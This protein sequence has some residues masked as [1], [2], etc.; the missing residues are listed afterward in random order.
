MSAR[1]RNPPKNKKKPFLE[2]LF[3]ILNE[4]KYS[5][6]IHWSP[7]GSC[8]VIPDPNS[9]TREVIRNN[10]KRQKQFSSFVRQL[11]LYDFEKVNKNTGKREKEMIYKHKEFNKGKK[12]DE[13][14]LIKKL[15]NK[16]PEKEKLPNLKNSSIPN[17]DPEYEKKIEE[18]EQLD[19]ASKVEEYKN[20][21][22]NEE[23]TNLTNE[24]IL[25]YLINKT[26]EK[27]DNKR[28]IRNEI[29]NLTN[30][31][32][33]L[34]ENMELLKAKIE[35]LKK[36]SMKMKDMIMFLSL[37]NFKKIRNKVNLDIDNIN[38]L[39][40]SFNSYKKKFDE[41]HH[42]DIMDTEEEIEIEEEIEEN[43]NPGTEVNPKNSEPQQSTFL[44]PNDI[45]SYP[46]NNPNAL[47]NLSKFNIPFSNGSRIS[48][49]S[50]NSNI[51]N[52][53]NFKNI[54]RYSNDLL[55]NNCMALTNNNNITN[56][57][58]IHDSI[59]LAENQSSPSNFKKGYLYIKNNLFQYE[60]KLIIIDS[61]PEIII[62]HPENNKI[63][64]E[65]LLERSFK[66]VFVN[67][68]EFELVTKDRTYKFKD[69]E[70]NS[71]IWGKTIDSIINIYS[72]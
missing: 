47:P 29:N 49:E 8:I 3:D 21:L 28:L 39:E 18:I 61:I 4:E 71:K 53:E 6:Y 13:I 42:L 1:K 19:E 45:I 62:I 69:N 17:E 22:K 59:F 63:E 34:I 10:F 60:K 30:E 26:K 33:N 15:K 56:Q 36:T 2:K 5:Q 40:N 52:C 32:I 58:K 68:N 57:F 70:V 51:I 54:E 23:L 7:D 37:I 43:N 20:I 24:K 65:I 41:K 46:K 55:I 48:E 44:I 9:F 27:N 66:V 31:N 12:P 16:S 38:N 11:N 25:N 67:K 14:K 35:E 72:K 64:S 50:R